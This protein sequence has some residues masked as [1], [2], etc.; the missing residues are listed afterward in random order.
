M[1][2]DR[3]LIVCL[4]TIPT[5]LMASSCVAT[6]TDLADEDGDYAGEE[7]VGTASQAI[8]MI[9]YSKLCITTASSS[10]SATSN[11]VT[12]E[13]HRANTGT[14]Y[15]CSFPSGVSANTTACCTPTTATGGTSTYS[16]DV[17]TVR[18]N[19]SSS[20]DGLKITKVAFTG[21]QSANVTVTQQFDKFQKVP[22]YGVQ[23]DGG[24]LECDLFQHN[25]DT[26]WLDGSGNGNCWRM[27]M[28]TSGQVW[29]N[30]LGW[31]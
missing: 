11:A 9:S 10:D 23:C 8:N 13:A 25:C 2:I 5:C 16:N 12:L 18:F 15:K 6:D 27:N 20:G 28:D 22:P 7:D 3:T 14:Y 1:K 31:Y 26:C 17:W 30:N 21:K 4:M 19:S 29:S 24:G